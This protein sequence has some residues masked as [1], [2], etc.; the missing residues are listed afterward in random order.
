MR[1][2]PRWSLLLVLAVAVVVALA[3]CGGNSS[4]VDLDAVVLEA[5][6][7]PAGWSERPNSDDDDA[8]LICAEPSVQPERRVQRTFARGR[9]P[10]FT[11]VVSRYASGDAEAYMDELRTTLADCDTAVASGV[12][13]DVSD[14]GLPGYG[15]DSEAVLIASAPGQRIEFAGYVVYARHGDVISHA[16]YANLGDADA[17]E[18]EALADAAEERFQT[19]E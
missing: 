11:H 2:I 14:A 8:E 3:A 16:V 5:G 7:L 10:L 19:Q 12:A 6:D 13:A 18:A 15:D 4:E 1:P 9:A 17:A